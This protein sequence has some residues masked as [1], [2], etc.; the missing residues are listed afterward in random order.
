MARSG[1]R[2]DVQT[3]NRG[4]RVDA[5]CPTADAAP[6]GARG[7]TVPA[8]VDAPTLSRRLASQRP[9]LFLDYD[10]TLTPIVQRPE[11]AWLSATGRRALQ[12]A[13]RTM[14]VAV[15]SGRDLEDVRA[16]VGVPGISYAGSHGLDIH[17]PAG[18][19]LELPEALTILPDLDQAA[20]A[21]AD[22]LTSVPG[23]QLERKRFAVAIHY[24]QVAASEVD[25]VRCV[26]RQV[27]ARHARLRMAGGKRVF[28]LR[29]DVDWDKGRAALWLRSAL[30]LD[31]RDVLPIYFGDDQT[32]EDAF[33]ALREFGVGILV[34]DR[35]RRSAAHYRVPSPAAVLVLLRHL[36]ETQARH[37]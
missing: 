2:L 10:G 25:R 12:A 7:P 14:P 27:Q 34:T 11:D 18:L 1:R 16:R 6:A 31:R 30:G 17:G 21:L 13:A 15:I 3:T 23:A 26:V 5:P 4:R 32:D 22:Q 24:R 8:L 28:E 33:A 37:R 9:A 36:V 29:P 35:P 19:R 20:A